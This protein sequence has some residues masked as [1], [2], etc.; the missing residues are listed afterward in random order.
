MDG[1]LV[2]PPIAKEWLFLVRHVPSAE[3]VY[4]AVRGKSSL[5]P[6]HFLISCGREQGDAYLRGG[7]G[8]KRW[9][10]RIHDLPLANV[11]GH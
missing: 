4:R 5:L 2:T 3:S 1:Q 8:E 10:I 7:E 11:S 9:T 6:Y